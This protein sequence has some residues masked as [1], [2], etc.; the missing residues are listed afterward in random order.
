ME[1]LNNGTLEVTFSLTTKGLNFNTGPLTCNVIINLDRDPKERPNGID[2]PVSQHARPSLI[3][4]G[5]SRTQSHSSSKH[6]H[7]PFRRR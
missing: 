3:L 5:N 7:S 1:D 2:L 6:D 4:V